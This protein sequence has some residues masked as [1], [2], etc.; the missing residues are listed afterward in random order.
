MI[1]RTDIIRNTGRK[2]AQHLRAGI[3]A[4]GPGYLEPLEYFIADKSGIIYLV[5]SKA[6][7]SSIKAMLLH[8][9]TGIRIEETGIVHDHPQIRCFRKHA[10]KS[11]QLE[12]YKFTFV[13]NPIDRL[14]SFYINKFHDV[15]KIRRVGFEFEYYLGGVFT[16][17]ESFR[18]LTEK[19]CAIPDRLAN[20]HF[21][22]QYCQLIERPP[23]Q[24]DYFGKIENFDADLKVISDKFGLQ[25]SSRYNASNI[26]KSTT[27]L[28]SRDLLDKV[29]D[30]YQTDFE[31][32]NYKESFDAL[33]KEC[34]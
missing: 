34:G 30:R 11:S 5:N 8:L 32:F 33:W 22:S 17:F 2:A 24:L 6:A 15:E 4:A 26:R 9:E 20:R 29:Y 10:L 28:F 19:I 16:P 25:P 18:S 21:I 1:S 12:F 13:R 3:L 23:F 14:V 31:Y 7:C 27:E